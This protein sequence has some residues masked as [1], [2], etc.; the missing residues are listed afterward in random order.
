MKTLLFV[1]MM[2][3]LVMCELQFGS[4]RRCLENW[5]RRAPSADEEAENPKRIKNSII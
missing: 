5:V 2:V 3:L 1:S 4:L